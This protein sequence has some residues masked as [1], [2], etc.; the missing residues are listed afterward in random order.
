M[1]TGPPDE[2]GTQPVKSA[3]P[4]DPLVG[5]D[6]KGRY[7]ILERL[8][9]GGMASAYL[10][11]DLELG[12]KV[13]IKVPRADLEQAILD[14][15]QRE[16]AAQAELQHPHIVRVR[17][18]GNVEVNGRE[19]PFVVA[20][21]KDGGHL[22]RR[23]KG[24]RQTFDEV[25]AWLLPIGRALDF[26]HSRGWI[27]R[28]VKP[29]N[30]LFDANGF[31]YLS[32]FG[33]AKLIESTIRTRGLDAEDASRA[34]PTERG[35]VFGTPGYMPPE[36]MLGGHTPAYDQY[37]LAVVVA[38]ALSGAAP[39]HESTRA[40][41]EAL[42]AS[43]PMKAPRAVVRALSEEP[44]KRF[45][46]CVEFAEALRMET[47]GRTRGLPLAAAAGLGVLALAVAGG[48]RVRNGSDQVTADAEAPEGAGRESQEAADVAK[49]GSAPRVFELGSSAA[50]RRSALDLCEDHLGDDCDPDWYADEARREETLE[51]YEIDARE[52]TI[53]EFRDFA[54]A[55]P[56]LS[57]TAE[58]RGASFVIA[59]ANV[60]EVP[61]LSWR[62]LDWKPV[63]DE[64]VV[65]V[66]RSDAA[67]YCA[68]KQKRLPTAAEW[69]ALARGQERRIFPW[70]DEWDASRARWRGI[71]ELDR[72]APVARF[73]VAPEGYYDL[74]GNVWEWT[75]SE[76]G[77]GLAVLKGGSWA[78]RSPA[79]LRGAMQLVAKPTYTA[80]D[81]GFRCA[82]S[83]DA[84]PDAPAAR[85]VGALSERR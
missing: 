36:A 27:H 46:S 73:D 19:L 31:V 62:N 17:G 84:W 63:D 2:R 10:A 54:A 35:F 24:G 85:R 38:Q 14:R 26:S 75:S 48:W 80:E 59:G 39:R 82:R 21:F 12:Q 58:E 77:D 57:T 40:A 78:S 32:D 49:L 7:R 61:Q 23:L 15:F 1:T 65:H 60:L 72:P 41:T 52:V 69:E 67:A 5:R 28:D 71:D 79:D 13:V 70:G 30:I 47:R 4:S 33:I 83:T 34:A 6:L 25:A 76:N 22:G 29:D 66:S 42:L 20:D 16:V 55:R 37:S 81:V 53:A 44:E 64:P 18:R 11:S 9:A 3:G 56:G 45:A 51:P 43:L 74:A 8:G 50:E 68:W